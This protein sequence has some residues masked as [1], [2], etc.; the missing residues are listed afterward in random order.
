MAAQWIA[1]SYSLREV[2]F[3]SAAAIQE[4]LGTSLLVEC[5][6]DTSTDAWSLHSFPE[7][8]TSTDRLMAKQLQSH[9]CAKWSI[10]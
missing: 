7:L 5:P 4:R 2:S 1:L 6:K 8:V 3:P 10:R 9:L